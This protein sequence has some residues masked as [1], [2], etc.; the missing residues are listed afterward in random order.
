MLR[1][2]RLPLGQEPLDVTDPDRL[3]IIHTLAVQLARMS[4]NVSQD[5]RERELFPDLLK[6]LPE[7]AFLGKLNVRPRVHVQRTPGHAVWRPFPTA[8]FEDLPGGRRVPW[9][10]A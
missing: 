6:R 1:L 5:A 10:I 7:L 9:M 3:V 8:P 4:A 2:T